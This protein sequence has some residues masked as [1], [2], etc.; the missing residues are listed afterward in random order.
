MRVV[1]LLPQVIFV[2]QHGHEVAHNPSKPEV[3]HVAPADK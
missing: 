2:D 3:K 1:T